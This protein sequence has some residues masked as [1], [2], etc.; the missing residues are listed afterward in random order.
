MTRMDI[1]NSR[2]GH[3]RGSDSESE[4]PPN[5]ESVAH[6]GDGPAGGR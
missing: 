2:D 4:V 3:W 6:P 5:S 1:A